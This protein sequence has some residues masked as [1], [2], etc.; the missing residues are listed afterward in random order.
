MT[1][2]MFQDQN[3]PLVSRVSQLE[4]VVFSLVG[5]IERLVVK[6]DKIYGYDR[7]LRE[8]ELDDSMARV[9][10]EKK[11]VGAE[12][13]NNSVVVEQWPP[14]GGPPG[15][16]R[17]IPPVELQY[18]QT[19]FDNLTRGEL[20]RLVQAY[21][22]ALESSHG[23]LMQLRHF[24]RGPFWGDDGCGGEALARIEFLMTLAGVEGLGE[25][26]E[27]AYRMFFRYAGQ[28]LFP[29]VRPKMG[30]CWGVTSDGML[31]APMSPGDRPLEWCDLLPNT[32]NGKC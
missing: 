21:H 19:P 4:D 26:N 24:Y 31:R 17:M 14:A 3:H 13:T 10:L 12:T 29:R 16:D 28:L 7:P 25:D 15:K 5:V 2:G 1:D 23:A 18:G 22:V 9:L 11:S 32:N 8:L 20:L 6:I 30:D 27:R